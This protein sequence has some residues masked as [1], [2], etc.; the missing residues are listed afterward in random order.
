MIYCPNPDCTDR[1]NADELMSCKTCGTTLVINGR[2]Q[3]LEP[4]RKISISGCAEVFTV[5]DLL[6]TTKVMKILR[7][8]DPKLLELFDRE[9]RV[10]QE[11]YHHGIPKME[12]DGY[13]SFQ[14][15]AGLE[16]KCIVMEKIAG[17]NLEQ[18]IQKNKCCPADLALQWL[19]Q[20]VDIL[21]YLHQNDLFHRDIK[22]ANIIL[23]PDQQIALVD[24]GA[25]RQITNTV[26]GEQDLTLVY[27]P[28]YAPPEQLKGQAVPQSDFYAL[29]RTFVHLLTGQN[30]L[31]FLVKNDLLQWRNHTATPCPKLL[32]DLIDRLMTTVDERPR[33]T[34][35]IQQKIQHIERHKSKL[36]QIISTHRWLPTMLIAM[37]FLIVKGS[38][39]RPISL[40][41]PFITYGEKSLFPRGLTPEKQA[42]INA[43]SQKNYFQAIENFQTVLEKNPDD[44]EAQIFLHNA[45][46]GSRKS[47]TLA[48]SVS[49]ATTRFAKDVG[50]LN[51]VAKILDV[52][53]DIENAAVKIAILRDSDLNSGEKEQAARDLVQQP[54]VM[55]VVVVPSRPSQLAVDDIYCN[56]LVNIMLIGRTTDNQ[57]SQ[58]K[59]FAFHLVSNERTEAQ[60]L[61]QQIL[62]KMHSQ[63][64]VILFWSSNLQSNSIK[65][66]FQSIF[67]NK[68]GQ[69]VNELDMS[70]KNISIPSESIKKVLNKAE[71]I[72]VFPTP[73]SFSNKDSNSNLLNVLKTNQQ[74]L[75]ILG[76]AGA[77]DPQLLKMTEKIG[78]PG[79]GIIVTTPC[80][81][82]ISSSG[83]W[84][85]TLTQ[86]AIK[87]FMTALK[88]QT[89]RN[90]IHQV[91]SA[92][93]F[94]VKGK[95]GQI[96]F[97]ADG[98]RIIAPEFVQVLPGSQSGTGYDFIPLR[99]DQSQ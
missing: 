20:L 80:C 29:G 57:T 59:G 61:T 70:D 36:R 10:L 48:V 28:A 99:P 76:G 58:C 98:D 51:G 6:S 11:L 64:V 12:A 24:F 71:A 63:R 45:R 82:K 83:Y 8:G 38:D 62:S 5:Q 13:F 31:D 19:K 87:V 44:S 41:S 69:I 43:F 42:G 78:G 55:G 77:F 9:A 23:K 15:T 72:V 22:P 33:S 21:K 25:V 95:S 1:E 91:I 49:P 86:D 89:S 85:N 47:R 92:P 17:I 68:G 90:G 53:K 18:W 73:T 75:P 50:A 27:T 97:S 94:E 2:Y 16:L 67:K 32:A 4:L 84:R 30:P 81:H 88:Q 39:F 52:S 14:T 46:I 79:K 93:N 54:N 56:K 3:L 7:V 74:K 34:D 37:P 35:L 40:G 65:L 66:E 26:L 96:R 60:F